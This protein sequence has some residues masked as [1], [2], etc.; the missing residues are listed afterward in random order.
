[1][2]K[3]F[4]AALSF[5]T[6]L[7]LPVG[8]AVLSPVELAACFACFPPVGAVLGLLYA[9]AAAVCRPVF[10]TL[11]LAVTITAL[12]A[13]LTRGL[14]LD[15]LADF[16]D[17]VGG[18]G[19]PA[20]RL[21]I[22]KD[23]RTGA[24]GATALVLLLAF[25]IAAL[26]AILASGSLAPLLLAPV[27]SRFAMVLG[28]FRIPYARAEGGL[29]KPF[30]ENMQPRQPAVAAAFTAAIC[31]VAAPSLMGAAC[32]AAVLCLTGLFRHFARKWLGGVTGDVLGALSESTETL[33]LVIAA[34][35][36]HA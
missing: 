3:N 27:L 19:S 10:P 35:F 24:F 23:S 12:A 4:A 20:R 13:I 18:G 17:G 2:F 16:A 5:L 14:H 25:K 9:L 22:M 1:M 6:I 11:L 28:A 21:E 32:A 8:Q 31:F 29:A 34:L 7:R 36:A 15:G 30:V 33:V 26:D